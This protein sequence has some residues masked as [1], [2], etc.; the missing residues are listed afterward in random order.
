M[1]AITP[2]PFKAEGPQPLLRKIPEGEPYPIHAL[3]PLRDAVEAV[4]GQS[5]API[6]IAAQSAI[7][8]ASLGVQGFANVETL[9]G[10]RAISLYCLTIALSGER[11]SSCDAPLMEAVRIFEQ[12]QADTQRLEVDQYKNAKAIWEAQHKKCIQEAG[13]G[14]DKAA[15][16]QADLEALGPEPT[17][18]PSTDRTVSE[19]TYEGLVRK[20]A[21]GQPSLGLFSDEG[22]QFLGGFAMSKDQRLKTLAALNDLWQGN[23]IQR[24]RAGEGSSVLYGRRL[25]IH[26]MAQPV[27]LRDF[28]A[29]PMTAET[30]F[31]P[32]FLITEPPS[33]IGTRIHANTRSNPAALGAFSSRLTSILKTP[34][35]MDEHTRALTPRVLP[36][37]EQ[38]REVLIQFSDQVETAMGDGGKYSSVTGYASKTAE[39][40]ARIAAVLTL[41]PD[42]EAKQIEAQTMAHAVD[43]AEFHL[44]EALRLKDA[45]IIS[46]ETAKAELLRVWLLDKWQHSEILP[47]EVVQLG[48]NS[49][50]ERPT[51][52]K[53]I[54]TL[55]EAGW[56]APLEPDTMVRG[57]ARKKAYRIVRPTV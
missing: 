42:L 2:T 50:R 1:N 38:A 54:G 20:L 36:L 18:P 26:L 47:S 3:G 34:L 44:N 48:P 24:T 23:P 52:N 45:A 6:A 33:T 40:A 15:A 31:L 46:A 51:A 8:I 4:Q 41:W 56:L 32:R 43:L 11:K 53:T 25:A 37:S 39:Q 49:L 5:Q 57:K 28:M 19:P 27:V 13:K 9:G 22:G 30:G 16:A 12:E 17:P 35:P 10:P 29:D 7:S 14:K 21:E 55:V